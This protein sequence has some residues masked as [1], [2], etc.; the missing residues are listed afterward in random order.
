MIYVYRKTQLVK[1]LS[2]KDKLSF[3]TEYGYPEGTVEDCLDFLC[4]RFKNYNEFPHEI[5]GV[6]GYPLHDIK[7]F[8]ENKGT[9]CKCA[10]C[11]KV[12]ADECATKKLFARYKRCKEVFRQKQAQGFDIAQLTVAI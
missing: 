11:W 8:I 6:L 9:N 3:L 4:G 12:Y 10:G 5:G 2:D 1:E 7:A